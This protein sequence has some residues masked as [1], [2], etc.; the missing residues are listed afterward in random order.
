MQDCVTGSLIERASLVYKDPPLKPL[1][2]IRMQTLKFFYQGILCNRLGGLIVPP[3]WR[4]GHYV[5]KRQEK[6]ELKEMGCLVYFKSSFDG[7]HVAG[8]Y[9][10]RLIRM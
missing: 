6:Y 3:P 2:K 7:A 9:R 10:N 8:N 4:R 5:E 1:E